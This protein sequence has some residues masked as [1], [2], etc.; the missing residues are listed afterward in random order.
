[1]TTRDVIRASV[2]RI[3]VSTNSAAWLPEARADL[4]VAPAE[5]PVPGPGE[6]LVRT[7]AVAVNP[8]DEV[9][10]HTGNLMYRWLPYP[11]VLGEDVAGVVVAVGRGVTR[12]A[13]GDRVVAY[14]VGMERG[15]RHHAEGGFQSFVV[16]REGL[17]APVPDTLAFHDAVVLPLAVSTAATALFQN[18]HLAL[19]PPTVP[20]RAE[21]APG[22]GTVVV[23]GGS[24]S[25][26]SN[27]I[28][29]AAASGHRVAATASPRNHERMRE[30]G[31]DVVVDYRDSTAVRQL[32]DALEGDD[33][34][35]ILAVGTG[36]GAPA[37]ALAVATGAR[38]VALASPAVSFAELP[39]RGGPSA[40]AVRTLTRMGAS[41]ALTQLTARRH[42][43]TA[44]FVWGST[45]MSNEVGRM[46]WHDYL[47]RA[48]A[49]GTHACAP[50]AEVVGEGL[51]AIQTAIDRLRAGV[52][53]TKLVVTL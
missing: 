4:V 51:G 37:V 32:S 36:S 42:G 21:P 34:K 12:F 22:R 31:A 48:L 26:G 39:R 35:G 10:Q 47:P 13:P 18:D 24:T 50:T 11:V 33:V 28:Q 43:I 27:A 2:E 41:T 7:R 49:D 15:S 40:A 46:L 8:L 29:L 16:V 14:A 38:R 20:R 19:P 5:M 3:P 53:A 25:V 6:L 44:S 30:L 23:W 9:K 17:T 1:M 45:L 52:S